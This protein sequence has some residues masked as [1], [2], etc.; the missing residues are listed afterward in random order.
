M[1]DILKIYQV[2]LVAFSA[3]W[4]ILPRFS[5]IL[6]ALMV[7]TT[8]I[9]AVKRKLHFNPNLTIYTMI[10]LYGVYVISLFVFGGWESGPKLL[11][12]KLS[13][14]I[15]PLIL[16]FSPRNLGTVSIMKGHIIGCLM[17]IVIGF[18]HGLSCS[19][20]FGD[21]LRCFST[22]HFSQIHHPSYFSVFLILSSVIL[23]FDS[24]NQIFKNEVIKW[25]VLMITILVQWNLGSLSGFVTMGVLCILLPGVYFIKTR[26]GKPLMLTM[27]LTSIITVLFIF[28]SDEIKKDFE[29]AFDNVQSY[30]N[31]PKEF[32][33][34]KSYIPKGN[35]SR[36]ILWYAAFQICK[37]NPQG[38][39]IG[40]L[41]AAMEKELIALG[42][43]KFAAKADNPHNQFLQVTANLGVFGLCIFLFLIS[44][45]LYKSIKYENYILFSLMVSLC[46]FCMFESMLQRQSGIVFFGLWIPLFSLF[47]NHKFTAE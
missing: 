11:E 16:S 13:F 33:T 12:Y 2:Q 1:N 5:A 26:K 20:E 38:V 25:G 29:N 31:N 9:G 3:M 46:I 32:V 37:D 39:G 19:A 7:L 17:L 40:N 36:L 24:K 41:D 30:F 44:Y 18:Y 43:E 6:I 42:H 10:M 8:I 45:L 21:S 47:F 27:I 22:T 15:F 28:N 14:L 23:I 4:L 34:Y 35:E